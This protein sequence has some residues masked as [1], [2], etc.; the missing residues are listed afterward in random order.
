MLLHVVWQKFT[1]VSGAYCLHHH[2]D[3]FVFI[4][5]VWVIPPQFNK[6]QKN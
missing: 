3:E 6:F 2:G 4:F 5:S 1:D